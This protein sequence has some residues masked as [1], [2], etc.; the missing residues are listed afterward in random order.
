MA[1]H[2]GA[3]LIVEDF[4]DDAKMLQTALE[5]AGILNRREVVHG[6]SDAIAYLTRVIPYTDEVKYPSVSVILLDLKLPGRDGFQFLEWLKIHPEFDDI[7]VIVISGLDDLASIRRAY[8][9]GADSF[10]TKPCGLLDL[11]NLMQ[12][13]PGYWER[14]TVKVLDTP[15]E[16]TSAR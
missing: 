14:L 15:L 9:L 5:Q 6:V 7:L 13:F 1:A 16:T 12:W 11:D 3:I 10:L 2:T 4:V 8:A